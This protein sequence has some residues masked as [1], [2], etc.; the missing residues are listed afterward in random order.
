M[1]KYMQK[2]KQFYEVKAGLAK[3]FD[4]M[5][6]FCRI[7]K[8]LLIFVCMGYKLLAQKLGVLRSALAL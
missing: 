5:N 6:G 3:Y 4:N 8:N 7:V 1:K 2:Y